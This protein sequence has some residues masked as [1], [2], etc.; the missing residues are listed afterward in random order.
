[1]TCRKMRFAYCQTVSK[2]N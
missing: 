1:M 2:Y